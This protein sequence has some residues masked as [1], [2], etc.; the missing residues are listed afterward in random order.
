[1][2]NATFIFMMRQFFVNFPPEL[3]QAVVLELLTSLSLF[4]ASSIPLGLSQL[5]TPSSTNTLF[6]ASPSQVPKDKYK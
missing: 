2:V 5:T 3:E 1:M 4:L 6:K